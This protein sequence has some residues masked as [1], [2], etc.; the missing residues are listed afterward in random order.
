MFLVENS[1]SR[2]GSLL[3]HGISIPD[4]ERIAGL[5]RDWLRPLF[6]IPI[7]YL[8]P[9]SFTHIVNN[10]CIDSSIVKSLDKRLKVDKNDK[11]D[12]TDAWALNTS[13][14]TIFGL[15]KIV[16]YRVLDSVYEVKLGFG[17]GFLRSPA[18]IGAEELS[19]HALKTI[20][21]SSA[22]NV[23]FSILMLF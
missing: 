6:H 22:E 11:S 9:S 7:H 13:V 5:W 1:A 16:G 18:I 10:E 14:L 15:G 17:T 3:P 21:I 12:I 4:R 8:Y 19:S 20:G 2:T 23:C